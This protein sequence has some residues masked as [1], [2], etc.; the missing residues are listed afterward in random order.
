M[1]YGEKRPTGVTLTLLDTDRL[2]QQLS[3]RL[4]GTYEAGWT[5]YAM[6]ERH[7]RLYVVCHEGV[8]WE[9]TDD[10]PL[11]VD[12]YAK[13]PGHM[14]IMPSFVAKLS[15]AEVRELATDQTVDLA[16]HVRQFGARL[17]GNFWS[18][19]RRLSA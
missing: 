5:P 11:E 1:T 6:A 18:W 14:S 16:D 8:G 15:P 3:E 9:V 10:R 19:H 7:G 12:V 17:E 4:E 13:R 2:N